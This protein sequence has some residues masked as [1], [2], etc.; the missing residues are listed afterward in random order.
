M[1]EIV[2][3]A[4]LQSVTEFLPISSSGH[5]FVVREF[6]GWNAQGL[7]LLSD[8]GLHIGTLGAVCAYFIK[9]LI[10]LFKGVYIKGAPR[11]LLSCIF[12]GTLPIVVVGVLFGEKIENSLRIIPVVAIMLIGFGVVLYLADKIGGCQKVITQMSYRD[13]LLVGTAQCVALVPGVSRSGIT[14]SMA[15][16]LGYGRSEAARFSMLLS[17][18]AILGATG[19]Y[20]LRLLFRNN[21]SELPNSFY[22]GVLLSFFGGLFAVSFLMNWVKK[23]SFYPFMIYRIILGGILLLFFCFS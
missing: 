2:V 4:L 6:F 7:G 18:P 16:F 11:H 19:Y 23:H 20:F 10:S 17:V 1:V 13:A 5:L 8:L 9:D 22:W 3:L 14:M 21:L 15:R 12:L